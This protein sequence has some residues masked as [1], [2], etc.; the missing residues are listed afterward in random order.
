MRKKL[1][2]SSPLA[3]LNAS[4]LGTEDYSRELTGSVSEGSTPFSSKIRFDAA[5]ILGGHLDWTGRSAY[6][7]VLSGRSFMELPVI[8]GLGHP[9][10]AKVVDNVRLFAFDLKTGPQLLL[11]RHQG[12]ARGIQT[13]PPLLP[14]DD[15]A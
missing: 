3:S 10:A 12:Q 7:L 6:Q 13:D 2:I 5:Q 8:I 15:I 14:Y 11:A 1:Q 4:E 9:N